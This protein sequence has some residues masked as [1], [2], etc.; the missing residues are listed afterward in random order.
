M[1]L[2]H[3]CLLFI[4]GMVM[5]GIC[6]PVLLLLPLVASVPSPSR[7][8][9]KYCRRCCDPLDPPITP[10]PTAYQTPEIRTY[11]NMTILKGKNKIQTFS[12][13]SH[14]FRLIAQHI[15]NC[16]KGASSYHEYI[17]IKYRKKVL[18]MFI[19]KLHLLSLLD[20]H[21][22]FDVLKAWPSY[23]FLVYRIYDCIIFWHTVVHTHIMCVWLKLVD[24]R[25]YA[26]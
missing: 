2:I 10:H 5:T 13:P 19:N 11:I 26:Y 1:C 9:S 22:W 21:W 3:F 6:L 12:V 18:F 20:R 8:P 15:A 14:S 4:S 25:P 17:T 23:Y 7:A 16:Q 24:I